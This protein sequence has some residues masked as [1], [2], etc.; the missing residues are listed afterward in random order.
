MY[1]LLFLAIFLSLDPTEIVDPPQDAQI[2]SGTTAQFVCQAAYDKSLKGSFEV[3]WRKDG[4]EI[5]LSFE[6]NS[7]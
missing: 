3:I 2:I 5:S 1:V 4:Q 6:E 7:K